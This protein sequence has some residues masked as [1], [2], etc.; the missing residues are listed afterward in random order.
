MKYWGLKNR[1][2]FQTVLPTIV[3]TIFLGCYFTFVRMT[4]LQYNLVTHGRLLQTQLGASLTYSIQYKKPEILQEWI[5]ETLK[6]DKIDSITVYNADGTVFYGSLNSA[7]TRSDI[8]N[9]SPDR[10][11]TIIQEKGL[12]I[13]INQIY[14]TPAPNKLKQTYPAT[15]NLKNRYWAVISISDQL[16]QQQILYAIIALLIAFTCGLV[17][18]ILFGFKIA[19]EVAYPIIAAVKSVDAIGKGNFSAKMSILCQGEMALLKEGINDMADQLKSVHET[20]QQNIHKATQ[21]LRNTLKQIAIQNDE[22]ND[23]R[24]DALIASKA[25]SEFLANMSHEIRTPMNS[26]IGFTDLLLK[27]KINEEQKEYLTTIDKSS[28][29]LLTIINDILDLSKIEAGSLELHTEEFNLKEIVNDVI[30]MLSPQIIQ[31]KLKTYL[32][33]SKEIPEFIIQDALRLQQVLTNLLNNAIKFTHKGEINLNINLIS[34]EFHNYTLKFE[35]QDTGIGLSKDE[36]KKLFSSFSQAD[37]S[38]TRK[39]GGTGLGLVISKSLVEKMSGKIGVE[40]TIKKGSSFWF[41]IICQTP[42]I[43]KKSKTNK[44][45]EAKKEITPNEKTEESEEKSLSTKFIKSSDKTPASNKKKLDIISVDDNP[46]NLKLI[47]SILE[48]FGH[49]SVSFDNA[50]DAI[51]EVK[52]KHDKIDLIFM[53]L[54]MPNIDGFNAAKTILK[55]LKQKNK[56]IPI[57]ALTADVFAETKEKII[58]TGFHGYQTKPITADQIEKILIQY[59][60][61][62]DIEINPDPPEPHEKPEDKPS[63]QEQDK[64]VPL[65]NLKQALDLTGGN[66]ELVKEMQDMLLEELIAETPDLKQNFKDGNIEKVRFIVHKIQGGASYCGTV[67]LK[68]ETNK[69]ERLCYTLEKEDSKAL[70]K[71][72]SEDFL[73]LLDTINETI[74]ALS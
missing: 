4:A 34:K 14:F 7:L 57:I 36:V 21:E 2:I 3:V 12:F 55:L 51:Q 38:T 29:N 71:E 40:S 5:D 30:T 60:D 8:I 43:D 47:N 13:F 50:S 1:L 19:Q 72:L 25:K 37:T 69:V 68:E 63:N 65:I 15:V 45:E 35:V 41:T 61:N 22:L 39:F 33:I 49:N 73:Q 27:T 24:E 26:I 62:T 59:F 16:Y 67:R 23:A 9:L 74:K 64:K 17:I 66:E 6:N 31:K 11:N 70:R 44:K 42:I 20:M 56:D 28:K 53:D 46:S 18:A 54:Q 10:N 52:L 48:S 58:Q 32:N